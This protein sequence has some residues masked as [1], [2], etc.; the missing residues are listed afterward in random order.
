MCFVEF[1]H[2][3]PFYQTGQYRSESY[4]YIYKP[5]ME[6]FATSSPSYLPLPPPHTTNSWRVSIAFS[7]VPAYLH[8]P[9][10]SSR[11]FVAISN[12][13]LPWLFQYLLG[14]NHDHSLSPQNI[15]KSTAP[16]YFQPASAGSDSEKALL[17]YALPDWTILWDIQTRV[18]RLLQIRTASYL[19]IWKMVP[20]GMHLCT[21]GMKKGLIY[22]DI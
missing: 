16:W 10:Y 21:A 20:L 12:V 8:H 5:Y 2:V 4:N 13:F 1:H 11:I 9:Q 15:R 14:L 19:K 7:K 18:L 6:S 17:F 3:F 22:R